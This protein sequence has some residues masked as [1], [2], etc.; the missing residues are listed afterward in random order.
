VAKP[1]E[2]RSGAV[3]IISS[4]IVTT[5]LAFG[6]WPSVF[7]DAKMTAGLLDRLTHHC[8]I[9]ETSNDRW[10]FKNRAGS[11]PQ[12]PLPKIPETPS[13]GPRK[14]SDGPSTAASLLAIEL[15]GAHQLIDFLK[16]QVEDLRGDRN[17]WRRQAEAAQ[18][19][20]TDERAPAP[21]STRPWWKPLASYARLI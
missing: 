11:A 6:E 20:F 1:L 12:P 17:G 9:V 18:R 15:V 2:A 19:L 7:G 10:R 13:S 4:V 8:E 3:L 5:N 16:A 14:G 21:V